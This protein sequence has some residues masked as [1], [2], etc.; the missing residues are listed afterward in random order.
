MVREDVLAET[1]AV[2]VVVAAAVLL[3]AWMPSLEW[4]P[5]SVQE[6][7]TEMRNRTVIHSTEVD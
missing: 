1:L 5:W 3:E 6:V 7:A 4:V 2:V